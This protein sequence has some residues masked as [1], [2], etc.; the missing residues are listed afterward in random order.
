MGYGRHRLLR[1]LAGSLVILAVLAGIYLGL[2]AADRAI[3]AAHAIPAGRYQVAAGVSVVP[4]RGATIDVTRTEPGQREGSALFVLGTLQYAVVVTP[5]D[6]TLAQ[7]AVRLREKITAVPGYQIAD[8]ESGIATDAGVRG[9]QGIYVTPGREGRYA[10][11]L[12]GGLDVE[13]T[14][15]GGINDLRSR[16]RTVEASIRSLTFGGPA[17]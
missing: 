6:G 5:F 7:A 13:L 10:V 1:N 12:E 8:G 9:R 17:Q 4:P 3:P 15:A 16:L 2:P 11:F 14:V